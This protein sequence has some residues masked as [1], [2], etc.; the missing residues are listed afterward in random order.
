MEFGNDKGKNFEGDILGESALDNAL[1]GPDKL[2]T[3]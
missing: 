2:Y 3:G 1:E